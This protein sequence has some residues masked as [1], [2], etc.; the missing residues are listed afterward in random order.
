M[1]HLKQEKILNIPNLLTVLRI[2]L[3]PVV[4]WRFTVGDRMGALVFTC[5]PCLQTRWTA[6]SPAGL[7]R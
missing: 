2:A 1:E 6:S 7:A 3:L 5:W 4:V